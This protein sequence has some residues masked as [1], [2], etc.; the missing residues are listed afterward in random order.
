MAAGIITCPSCSEKFKGKGQLVGKRIK[1]PFCTQPFVVPSAAKGVAAGAAMDDDPNPY[2]ITNLDIRPRCPHCAN[3]MA[4]EDAFICLY[5]GY[6]TLTRELGQTKKVVAL[7]SSERLKHLM[8]GLIWAGVVILILIGMMFYCLQLQ[9]MLSEK[10]ANFFGHESLKMWF[11]LIALGLTWG[12]GYFA[13]KRLIL[14][15]R[16]E[17][18]KK[19][20]VKR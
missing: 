9:Y 6:N 19:T 18:K 5:C 10:W 4:D 11:T 8:P 2:G 16:P 7:S 13:V 20:E 14:E 3:L 15:P 17:E 12:I 1:C